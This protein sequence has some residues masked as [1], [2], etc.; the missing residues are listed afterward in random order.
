MNPCENMDDDLTVDLPMT[1]IPLTAFKLI[2]SHP[3]IELFQDDD[4]PTTVEP[5]VETPRF[6]KMVPYYAPPSPLVE[7]FQRFFSEWHQLILKSREF[8]RVHFPN[9]PHLRLLRWTQ[10][11]IARMKEYPAR[12]I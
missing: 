9:A 4:E 7:P 1:A 3:I 5:Y 6:L 11:C 10:L 12:Q 2:E 8:D